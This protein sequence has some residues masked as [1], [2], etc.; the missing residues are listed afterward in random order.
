MT[1]SAPM[2]DILLQAYAQIRGEAAQR[3]VALRLTGSIAVQLRCPCHAR[4][5]GPERQFADL[6]LV[7][8]KQDA[9]AVRLAL[10]QLGYGETRE[11]FLSSEGTR[12]IFDHPDSKVHVDVFYDRLD[13][14]HVIDVRHRLDHDELTLPLAELLLGK[15]QIVQINEKDIVDATILL[16]E[17]RLGEGDSDMINTLEIAVRCAEEWGLWRTVSGNLMKLAQ[18]A[19]AGHFLAPDQLAHLKDQLGTLKQSI[20]QY[21]KPLA[22]RL[23]ARLGDKMKWYRDVEEVDS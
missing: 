20:D 10:E 22:W 19:D 2:R 18:Y 17:H 15:L 5:A 6:D 16:I 23:R 3:Q 9:D 8:R 7:A 14:C 13:F 11:I 1:H 4:L 12:A 21:P